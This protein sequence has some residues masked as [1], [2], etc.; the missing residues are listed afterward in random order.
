MVGQSVP[1]C[2]ILV[3]NSGVRVDLNDAD[4][5]FEPF[6]STTAVAR[7]LLGQG[8]GLGLTITRRMVESYRGSIR[9]IEPEDGFATSVSVQWLT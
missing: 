4:Q 9:F 8:M 7:P 3:Q 6:E 1:G 2:E 5:W